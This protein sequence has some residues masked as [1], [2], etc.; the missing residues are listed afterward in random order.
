MLKYCLVENMMAKEEKNFTAMVTSPVTKT[1]DDVINVMIAEGTGLTRPQALAYFEKLLQTTLG[2]LK[3][4]HRVK[5]PLFIVR[6][7]ISGTFNDIEDIFD[8]TRHDIRVRFRPGGRMQNVAA[9]FH[10]EKVNV[11]SMQPV[12]KKIV[13]AATLN[14]NKNLTPGGIGT[15]RGEFLQFDRDN[16]SLGVFFIPVNNPELSI[17]AMIYSRVFPRELSFVIPTLEPG[18]YRVMVKSMPKEDILST[19]LAPKVTV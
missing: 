4:G 18:E 2:F 14:T 13:D 3:D 8:V 9:E 10:F 11:R 5:T 7:T 16:L 12:V 15:I 17:R 19:L 1:L 6:P